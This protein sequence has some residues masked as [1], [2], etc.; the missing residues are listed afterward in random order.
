MRDM[1]DDRKNFISPRVVEEETFIKED[2]DDWIERELEGNGGDL[3]SE[4]NDLVNRFS[5][6]KT[7]DV[8]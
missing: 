4:D 5:M 3:R 6:P 2:L 1:D 8:L 7:P